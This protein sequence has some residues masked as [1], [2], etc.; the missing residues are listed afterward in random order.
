MGK[1]SFVGF[2][3]AKQNLNVGPHFDVHYY[4]K[5]NNTNS[6]IIIEQKMANI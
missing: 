3:N 4:K 1:L 6:Q 5:K 2:Y